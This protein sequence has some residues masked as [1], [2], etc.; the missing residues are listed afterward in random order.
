[1]IKARFRG[2]YLA[3]FMSFA[4]IVGAS[5]LQAQPA[6]DT[7]GG[8][9]STRVIVRLR[10][11]T[12]ARS[13]HRRAAAAAD[14]DALPK[15]SA[16]LRGLAA[17]WRATKMRRGYEEAFANPALA[18]KHGLDRT[19]VLEVPAG[20]DTDRLAKALSA[21]ADEVE[22]ASPDVIGGVAGDPVIPADS[23]FNL[24]WGMHN[25]GQNIQGLT[26][27][28]DA[29]IDAPEAWAI[30]TGVG[31]NQVIV[32]VVDSGVSSHPEYGN[33]LGP[34]S[35]GRILPGWNTVLNSG[36]PANLTDNCNLP[37]GHGTHVAGTIGAA[38]GKSCGSGTSET[39]KTC[40]TVEDC[41]IGCLGGTNGGQICITNAD[42]PGSVC[43]TPTC[44]AV[45]VVGMSWG[46]SLL[47]VKVLTNCNGS[48]ADLNEGIIWAADHG[49]NVI[50]LSV[51]FNLTQQATVTAMQSAVNYAHDAGVLLV[52]ATGNN[53]NCSNSLP[54]ANDT[55]CYP[56]KLS[57]VLAVSATD[58]NDGFG[59]FANYGPEVDV[60][61]PGKDVRSTALNGSYQY[62]FGTSMATPHVAG[63]AALIKSYVPELTNDQIE[64][65]IETSAEDRGEIGWDNKFGFGRINAHL[66][67]LAAAQWPGILESSPPDMAIDAGQPFDPNTLEPQG[68][69]SIEVRFPRDV[70]GVASSDF[71][72][73]QAVAGAAPIVTAIEPLDIDRVR[74]VLDRPIDPLAWT[75]LT[76]VATGSRVRLGFLPGDCDG[77][78]FTSPADILALIDSLNE[79]FPRPLHST[80]IDRSGLA[81]P[82]DILGL[83]D[84]LNGAAPYASYNGASLPPLP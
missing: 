19:F 49:A 61:A 66:A 42:C 21:L 33:N 43:G 23:Q 30:H 5:G 45:G 67:L 6:P 26:G 81:L 7:F 83:I 53:D 79:V 72:I 9:S 55:V 48:S 17:A 37:V 62:L 24:Q 70:G 4:T 3:A 56:A 12:F 28:E 44:S 11:D 50:N 58:N 8:N 60:A 73:D 57:N 78:A 77:D 71:V 36:A 29:D 38:G 84:L 63:L 32:A 69:S 13:N 34:N 16:R 65:I 80:D 2:A 59:T 75:T 68:W 35:T 20:T 52:A 31:A 46:V 10:A 14:A 51:Q 54:P 82:A 1:M 64:E 22:V 40:V 41:A 47:P 76:H 74:V 39:G 15:T 18:E 27:L 25:T